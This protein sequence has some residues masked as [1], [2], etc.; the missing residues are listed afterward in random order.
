MNDVGTAVTAYSILPNVVGI[1][2]TESRSQQ[3]YDKKVRTTLLLR[4][5]FL[6]RFN[7][8]GPPN[9]TALHVKQAGHTETRTKTKSSKMCS[10]SSEYIE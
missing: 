4:R 8:F 10:T 6:N 7:R 2:E 1:S 3:N 5:I 9:S